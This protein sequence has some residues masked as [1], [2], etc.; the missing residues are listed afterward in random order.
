M[1]SLAFNYGT[2]IEAQNSLPENNGIDL[3]ELVQQDDKLAE[4]GSGAASCA[5]SATLRP[6]RSRWMMP[7]DD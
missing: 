2:L 5:T 6:C 3:A 4:A 7:Q 1:Q